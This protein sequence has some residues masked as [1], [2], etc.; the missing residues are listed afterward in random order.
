MSGITG[1]L[2]EQRI[3]DYVAAHL[4]EQ[5][6]A[7]TG[8]TLA[9][10]EFCRYLTPEGDKCAIGCLFLP[11]EYM[12]DMEGKAVDVLARAGKL[13]D[14]FLPYLPLLTRLQDEHD[15]TLVGRGIM[16]SWVKGML[17]LA[18]SEGLS[19]DVLNCKGESS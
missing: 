15:V 5:G 17:K 2:S 3:F 10:S 16:S 11:G 7:A 6:H 1:E 14:R 18:R 13:P 12:E 4:L 8:K 9:G 19:A